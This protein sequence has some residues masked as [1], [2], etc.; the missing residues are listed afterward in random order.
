MTETLCVSFITICYNGLKDTCA[1]IDSIRQTLSSVS[2]EIIVVD[3]ASRAN[4]AEAIARKYPDVKTLRSPQNLGFSGGNNLGIQA[5]QGK[6]LFLINNDT[7][8]T[9]DGLPYLIERLESHPAIGAVSPKIRFAFPPQQIQFAGFTHLSP[10]TL[11]NES[12]GCGKDDNGAFDTPHPTPYLHGAALLLKREVIRRVGLMPEIYFLYYEELDWCTRITRAGYELWY[13]PRCT[14][15]HKESQSTGQQS[16]LRTFYLTR[17]RLLYAWRNLSGPSRYLSIAY[18][19]TVA[20]GKNSLQYLLKRQGSLA[21][22][23][24]KGLSAFITLPHKMN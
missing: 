20:A 12:I 6:Y 17:N 23:A 14:V 7:Y 13:E 22:A 11:R 8:F 4:E 1:L 3:N 9:T 18:Q 5:A 19:L 2:Y 10:I 15:F 21:V 24:F 16:P